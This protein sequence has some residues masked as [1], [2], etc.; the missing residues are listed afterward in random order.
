MLTERLNWDLGLPSCITSFWFLRRFTHKRGSSD[1][2]SSSK[3]CLC[4]TGYKLVCRKLNPIFSLISMFAN[5]PSSGSQ[6]FNKHS[7]FFS[8]Y[9]SNFR[10]TWRQN[11][12]RGCNSIT[13]ASQ[14]SSVMVCFNAVICCAC[15][16]A[17]KSTNIRKG[18]G[19]KSTAHTSNFCTS[20]KK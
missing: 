12:N 7:P 6:I 4:S 3:G 2:R 14:N 1:F 11:I 16:R 8:S 9:N 15:I 13:P 10:H 20:Q 19:N 18:H 5:K 17:K